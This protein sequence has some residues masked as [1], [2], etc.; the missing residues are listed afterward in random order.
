MT[1]TPEPALGHAERVG[2]AHLGVT[3]APW[4]FAVSNGSAIA[5]HWQRRKAENPSF[6]NGRVFVL[7]QLERH[8]G[9]IEATLSLEQ[10]ADFLY[11]RDLG[12][13]DTGTLD[14]FGSALVRSA[15]GHVLLGHHAAGTLNAGSVY[16]PGG[17]LDARDVTAGGTIDLDAS[18]ARELAEETGLDAAAL[19]RIP[20]VLLSR[21][22][23]YCAFAIEYRSPLDAEALRLAMLDGLRR[24]AEQE[25]SDIVIVRELADL[26][27]LPI[28][29]HA[30]FLVA[31][32]L[33]GRV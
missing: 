10:F 13:P 3:H 27:R 2:H 17:F 16:L 18:I 15:E 11:W 31:Q 9:S 26:D 5:A 20:G 32:V 12:Y 7:R 29:E 23:R 6:F 14:G 4:P 22:A 24:N 8:A 19:T 33:T 30:R 21:F 28:L 25:L 1:A